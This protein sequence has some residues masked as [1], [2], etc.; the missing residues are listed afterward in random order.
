MEEESC[1]LTLCFLLA[2]SAPT[3]AHTPPW[4]MY[5]AAPPSPLYPGARG[6]H[7]A[8]ARRSAGGGGRVLSP[9]SQLGSEGGRAPG[10]ATASRSGGWGKGWRA[11]IPAPLLAL[12]GR[13]AGGSERRVSSP[14]ASQ[15][16]ASKQPF[17]KANC[18][19]RSEP[20]P[21]PR[22]AWIRPS[23]GG[24][25][26]GVTAPPPGSRGRLS[27]PRFQNRSRGELER[28][29]EWSGTG[30][31]APSARTPEANPPR[32]AL[33]GGERPQ[34]RM[35]PALLPWFLCLPQVLQSS[36]ALCLE[37]FPA[38]SRRDVTACFGNLTFLRFTL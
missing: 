38:G 33:L 10:A 12:R 9:G 21:A 36:G 5:P 20:P 29:R 19:R 32:T 34:A 28:R 16:T 3:A 4:S 35:F 18:H 30:N 26:G 17:L 31:S 14:S 8:A 1:L 15:L 6:T 22:P 25:S 11:L 37:V 27:R 23:L 13:E 2:R 7:A 24:G